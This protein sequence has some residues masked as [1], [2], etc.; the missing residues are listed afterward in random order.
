MIQSRFKIY[1][2]KTYSTVVVCIGTYNIIKTKVRQKNRNIKILSKDTWIFLVHIICIY[3]HNIQ[4]LI[5]Y[6]YNDAI[7]CNNK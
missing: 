7:F 1:N 5:N 3:L 6:I 4:I 2:L